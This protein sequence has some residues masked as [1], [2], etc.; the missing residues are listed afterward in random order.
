[1]TTQRRPLFASGRTLVIGLRGW[2][3][4]GGAA[5]GAISQVVETAELERLVVRLDDEIYFDYAA[6]RPQVTT[7]EHGERVI[8]FPQALIVGPTPG[9]SSQV[10]AMAGQEPSL[11]WR[12]FVSEVINVCRL[13][14]IENIVLVGALLADAPHTREIRVGRT[15]EDPEVQHEFGLE[16]PS[17]E[18]PTGVMSVIAQE[19]RAVGIRVMSLWASV[20]HYSTSIESPSPKA[21]LA[22]VDALAELLMLAIDRKQ[23]VREAEEWQVRISGL[24]EQD[25][26]LSDY[27]RYLEET[28]DV[29]DSE[30]AT[31]DAIAAEFEQFLAVS[32]ESTSNDEDEDGEEPTR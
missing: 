15:S 14:Q 2:S 18:G 17:Y 8:E 31:G 32:G 19:A 12:T 11:R 5:S 4:A 1:M 22:L 24:I 25:D 27:V 20:P 6:T 10:Y 3:D 23:L 16:A 9:S 13:E 28:R 7:N 30:A 21:E 26:E 29:V